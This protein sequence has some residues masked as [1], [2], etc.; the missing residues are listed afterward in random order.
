MPFD[1][2]LVL[3]DD[4]AD[5]TYANLVTNTYGVPA[6]TT[7]NS[8]G[9]VVVDIGGGGPVVSGSVR[10]L[11]AV[12]ILNQDAAVVTAGDEL[13]CTIEECDDYD[14]STSKPH[15]L[16]E[17]DIAAATEGIILGSE[18]TGAATTVVRRI[19]VTRRYVRCKASC[20]SGDDFGTC[21]CLLS[22][23]PFKDL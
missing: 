11:A 6:L 9:F 15:Q 17:F 16:A 4:T 20:N 8:G 13:T 19:S 23:Y 12:L 18:V 1:D 2:N 7:R 22:P 21:W 10:G 3:A 5:W 14:F